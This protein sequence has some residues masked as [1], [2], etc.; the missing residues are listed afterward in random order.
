M[1]LLGAYTAVQ[2]IL[3]LS[4]RVISKARMSLLLWWVMFEIFMPLLFLV[5]IKIP[6]FN[7]GVPWKLNFDRIGR[8]FL[9]SDLS[10]SLSRWWSIMSVTSPPSFMYSSYERRAVIG[11]VRSSY[12]RFLK[13]VIC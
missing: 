9:F 1:S 12:A 10:F 13:V 5:N 3:V 2:S 4:G 11:K 6:L 7:V 8:F